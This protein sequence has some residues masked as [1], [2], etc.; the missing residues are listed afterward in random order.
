MGMPLSN[1][2]KATRCA[3]QGKAT[4]RNLRTESHVMTDYITCCI[5]ASNLDLSIFCS[6]R[7]LL[8]RQIVP[9]VRLVR[10]EY[11]GRQNEGR[12]AEELRK[13]IGNQFRINFTYRA[14]LNRGPGS[15]SQAV[16]RRIPNP[17][18]N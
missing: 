3:N 15:K 8:R 16:V 11:F 9:V 12:V 4:K 18:P 13:T 5:V 14:K 1:I 2:Q 7:P 6:F 17:F 10:D